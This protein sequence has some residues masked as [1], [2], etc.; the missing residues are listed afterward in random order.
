MIGIGISTVWA[1]LFGVKLSG[2][3]TLGLPGGLP[4]PFLD[5]ILAATA[6]RGAAYEGFFRSTRALRLQSRPVSARSPRGSR[7]EDNGLLRYKMGAGG[8]LEVDGWVLPLHNQLFV[9]GS[10]FT[11][12]CPGVRPVPWRQHHPGGD[13]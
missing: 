9:I 4:L 2:P 12:G 8:V 7:I 11:S 1:K 5:Q 10:E 13:P 3:Q 6:L